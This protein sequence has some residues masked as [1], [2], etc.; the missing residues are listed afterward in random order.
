MR[1]LALLL[2]SVPSAWSMVLRRGGQAIC[3]SSAATWQMMQ[4]TVKR[5]TQLASVEDVAVPKQVDRVII[6]FAGDSGDGMQLTG[7]RFTHESAAF[8]NDLVTLPNFPAETAPST[9]SRTQTCARIRSSAR[10]R[11]ADPQRSHGQFRAGREGHRLRQGDRWR[12]G[13]ACGRRGRGRAGRPRLPQS[14]PDPRV[15]DLP[16]DRR[17][18]HPPVADRHLPLGRA[19]HARRPG[20]RP[21]AALIGGRRHLGRDPRKGRHQ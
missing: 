14:R 5:D 4:L 9:R 20:P 8:G 12:Q 6:R 16:A 10:A 18:L 7:N 15:L 11:S 21:G 19:A 13:A 1:C 3:V 2:T 17:R